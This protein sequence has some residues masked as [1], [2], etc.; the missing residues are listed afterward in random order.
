[1]CGGGDELAKTDLFSFIKP[2]RL[3]IGG[4][5]PRLGQICPNPTWR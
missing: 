5:E 1:V 2:K 3:D 4:D